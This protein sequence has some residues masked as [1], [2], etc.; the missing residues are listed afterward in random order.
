[1]KGFECKHNVP[2]RKYVECIRENLWG[3]LIRLPQEADMGPL[4]D[5]ITFDINCI[6][7]MQLTPCGA[8]LT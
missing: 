2:F 7:P 4:N 1:M 5:V 3:K 6:S 8:S